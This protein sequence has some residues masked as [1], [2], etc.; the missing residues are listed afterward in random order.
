MECALG[1]VPASIGACSLSLYDS[2]ARLPSPPRTSWA[3]LHA[4]SPTTPCEPSRLIG[5]Y[6]AT[7]WFRSF[8]W[9]L[10]QVPRPLSDATFLARPSRRAYRLICVS[11]RSS[12]HARALIKINMP[13]AWLTS[14]IWAGNMEI[15]A[16]YNSPP[17]W[18]LAPLKQLPRTPWP[19]PALASTRPYCCQR[20]LTPNLRLHSYLPAPS[21]LT[22][23]SLFELLIANCSSR[24][25]PMCPLLT[26]P[27]SRI[28]WLFHLAP[29]CFQPPL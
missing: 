19:W 4:Q 5:H 13:L 17:S 14:L 24:D 21:P 6:Q 16:T 11:Y 8:P 20:G 7:Y 12:T 22:V 23:G 15:C 1:T 29:Y 10:S 18:P 2:Q 26:K 27:W 25:F 3:A 9:Y 28:L